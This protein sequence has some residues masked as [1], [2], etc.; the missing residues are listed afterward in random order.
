[1]PLYKGYEELR[2]ATRN[3]RVEPQHLKKSENKIVYR[4][5]EIHL[6]I[7]LLQVIKYIKSNLYTGRKR[8]F[9]GE[10]RLILKII[11]IICMHL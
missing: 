2:L 5:K 9:T 10:K 6:F 8:R 1:M 4:Q 7:L 11:T 3:L